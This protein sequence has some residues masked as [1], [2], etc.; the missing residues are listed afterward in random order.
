MNT[1]PMF[2]NLVPIWTFHSPDVPPPTP[3]VPEEPPD[4]PDPDVPPEKPDEPPPDIYFPPAPPQEMPVKD[5]P[6]TTARR[7]GVWH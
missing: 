5:P 3:S 6:A 2:G 4:K 7:A 1:D